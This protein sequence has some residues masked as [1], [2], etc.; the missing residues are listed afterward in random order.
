MIAIAI[1]QFFQHLGIP[2][3]SPCN[4]CSFLHHLSASAA[5]VVLEWKMYESHYI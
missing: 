5:E 2:Y 4:Q 1:E 3:Q